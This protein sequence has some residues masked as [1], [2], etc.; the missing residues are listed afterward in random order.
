MI[1]EKDH[2]WRTNTIVRVQN[3]YMQQ[4][5]KMS[6]SFIYKDDATAF[7]CEDTIQ[8]RVE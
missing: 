8:R 5:S 3:K 4:R 7:V 6:T 1:K 2:Y